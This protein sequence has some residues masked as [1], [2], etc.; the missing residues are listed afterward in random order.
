M[1]G[2]VEGHELSSEVLGYS[3]Q[4]RH[5]GIF[6]I[7]LLQLHHIFHDCYSPERFS[8]FVFQLSLAVYLVNVELFDGFKGVNNIGGL[9]TF[10]A[11]ADEE[12]AVENFDPER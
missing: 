2:E 6:R 8:L 12:T 5:V 10:Y 9:A 1:A 7:F 11:D 4:K 3:F